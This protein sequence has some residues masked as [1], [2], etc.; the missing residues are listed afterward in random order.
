MGGRGGS[1]GLTRVRRM[2][3]PQTVIPPNQP[4]QQPQPPQ[5]TGP[6]QNQVPDVNNTPVAPDAIAQLQGMSDAQLAQAYLNSQKVN[7]PNHLND[8][9]DK[10]QKF[11]FSIGL[12]D[13]PLVL[14]QAGFQQFMQQNNIPQAEILSRSVN[15]GQ[16]NTSAGNKSNLTAQ[17]VVDMLKYSRL[18]YIGGKHG[19]Q[20]LGAG[21]YLDMNGGGNTMYGG[22]TLKGVLNPQTAKVIT[23]SQLDRMARSFDRSHPQFARAT[24]GYQNSNTSWTNNNM[25]VYALAMGYNVIKDDYGGYHNVIDRKALVLL[26]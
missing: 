17:Q 10:T 24:G 20:K 21:A 19:G 6:I 7:L 13:K 16:L 3:Q 2:P 15:N 1:S 18:T 11:V 25:S 5:Q 12:N 22:T 8:A 14:D 26:K 9:N 23:R 4:P